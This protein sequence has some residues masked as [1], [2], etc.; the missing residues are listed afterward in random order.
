VPK[1]T[2]P[3]EWNLPGLT[4]WTRR[5]L[6]LHVR[7][8]DIDLETVQ[9]EDIFETL[10]QTVHSAY[11][12]R[13]RRFGVETMR[14][15][16]RVAILR[17]VDTRWK[18]HLYAMDLLKEGIGLRGHGGKDPLV[19]YKIEAFNLFGEI[20]ADVKLG[21]AEFVFRV[22]VGE[23]K[24]L[25]REHAPSPAAASSHNSASSFA[26]DAPRQTAEGPDGP[27]QPAKVPVKV[28]QKVGRNDPCP[29]GSGKKYKKCCGA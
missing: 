21:T 4:E 23:P 8:D 9:P 3:D 7:F 25:E 2:L 14:E 29:C 5:H 18:D 12:E 19:E 13:E 10:Q 17:A 27:R 20:I 6:G 11:E 26:G 22:Q 16:E 24:R 15:I 28:G 1:D